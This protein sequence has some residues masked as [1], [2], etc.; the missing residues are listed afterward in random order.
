MS[1]SVSE[2]RR[3]MSMLYDGELYEVVEYEHSKRGRS[4]AVGKTKLKHLKTGKTIPLTKEE[5]G[6]RHGGLFRRRRP[7]DQRRD[8]RRLGRR[9][10]RHAERY[11]PQP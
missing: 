1:L 7:Y 8:N 9:G 6:L 11:A 4:G 3:G 2:I 5:R 10:V